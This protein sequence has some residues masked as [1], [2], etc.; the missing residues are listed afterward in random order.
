M[1]KLSLNQIDD[2]FELLDDAAWKY[3]VGDEV[4]DLPSLDRD[5]DETVFRNTYQRKEI[6]TKKKR[7]EGELIGKGNV[8]K[9]RKY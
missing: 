2:S 1:T 5:I 6:R 3:E 9:H 4:E 8:R 7:E